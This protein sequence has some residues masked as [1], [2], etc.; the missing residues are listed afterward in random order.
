MT[1]KSQTLAWLGAKLT[2]VVTLKIRKKGNNPSNLISASK[3][4][5]LSCNLSWLLLT[6]THQCLV[7]FRRFV[8]KVHNFGLWY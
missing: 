7:T 2:A 1:L 3:D 6:D 5:Y 8:L 4:V